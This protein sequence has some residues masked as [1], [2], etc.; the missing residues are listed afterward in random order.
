[1]PNF[2]DLFWL[3]SLYFL[4]TGS[5]LLYTDFI[6]YV[7]DNNESFSAFVH[8]SNLFHFD[9]HKSFGLTDE[10]YGPDPA[11]HPYVYTHQ[12]NFPRLVSFLMYAVGLRSVETQ[13]AAIA[14]IVGG[15]SIALIWVFFARLAGRVF[16][17]VVCLLFISEYVFMTQWFVN[18]FK[19]WHALLLFAMLSSLQ[20]IAMSR[21]SK[22]WLLLLA[23][24][25]FCVGYFD[26]M[27][28]V[29]TFTVCSVFTLL[30]LPSLGHKKVFKLLSTMIFG[31]LLSVLLLISQ[32]ILYYGLDGLRQ[33]FY[34][35]F[36]LRN[37]ADSFAGSPADW[38]EFFIENRIV[39][40][41]ALIDSKLYASPQGMLKSIF[42][43][44]FSVFTPYF[45]FLIC[46]LLLPAF[47]SISIPLYDKL[48]NT[49]SPGFMSRLFLF[50]SFSLL[51][52]IICFTGAAEGSPDLVENFVIISKGGLNGVLLLAIGVS[53]LYTLLVGKSLFNKGLSY[54]RL[55]PISVYLFALSAFALLQ[56]PL[57]LTDEAP[58]VDIWSFVMQPWSVSG[59]NKFF[60][61]LVILLGI[62]SLI[63]WPNF[64]AGLRYLNVAPV[65]QVWVFVSSC[66]I[67]YVAAYFFSP[68][69]MVH[70]NLQRYA[71]ILVFLIVPLIAWGLVINIRVIYYAIE[72]KQPI[73]AAL[74]LLLVIHLAVFWIGR[75]WSYFSLLPPDGAKQFQIL[76]KLPYASEGF[77]VRNYAA[78]VSVKTN[79]WAY[80]NNQ[81]IA[82]GAY[83]LDDSGYRIGGNDTLKWFADRDAVKYRTP[84]FA[85]CYSQPSFA[86]ARKVLS[87]MKANPNVLRVPDDIY[88]PRF[89]GLEING[90]E[91]PFGCS[92]AFDSG[93][94]IGKNIQGEPR[95]TLIATDASLLH[96]WKLIELEKD[97]PPYLKYLKKQGSYISISFQ[98]TLQ[99]CFVNFTYAYQQQNSVPEN[100]S[101]VDLLLE[102]AFGKIANA[103][104]TGLASQKIRIPSDF[105]G[106][107]LVKI[108]PA[109]DSRIG[110]TYQSETTSV[111]NCRKI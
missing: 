86:N 88:S 96:R 21:V 108:T 26:L 22:N 79:A 51:I 63:K 71:P 62:W 27:M 105:Q 9:L 44:G 67:G 103:H 39:F 14:F 54:L 98:R 28:G 97:Y 85:L 38:K 42:Q 100:G 45:T 87:L 93:R 90:N 66:L 58:M 18:S 13:I 52:S 36:L 82:G 83:H 61:F 99:D 16:A 24:L 48:I 33:D 20:Q 57:Y 68:G 73:T 6:P 35:T 15:F 110:R 25:S 102:P 59:S 91:T 34:I 60:L 94:S 7:L 111:R 5:L 109:S 80:I 50:F 92:D 78:P 89:N 46:A 47:I 64:D 11:A 84:M 72:L 106:K 53:L 55:L 17:F 43:Y 70:I 3:L 40:W 31:G 2:S 75:Q 29:F 12:G 107:L 56:H 81:F 77:V 4:T 8:G 32:L 101:K 65:S 95:S 76:D 37:Y 10:A 19:A 49:K 41:E 104:L 69:Y 1:M 23:V 74:A 30:L